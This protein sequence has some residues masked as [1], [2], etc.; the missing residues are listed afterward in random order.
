MK[1]RV[2]RRVRAL[3]AA[4][5]LVGALGAC[6]LAT[7]HTTSSPTV[8]LDHDATYRSSAVWNAAAPIGPTCRTTYFSHR[9]ADGETAYSIARRYGA[10]LGKV[11]RINGLDAQ[12][13]IR[14]SQS[15]TIPV[16]R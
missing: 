13:T 11:A 12:F 2:L 5:L 6:T 4:C 16:C 8:A 9:V 10:D 15:L 1:M 7:V 3:T 14:A